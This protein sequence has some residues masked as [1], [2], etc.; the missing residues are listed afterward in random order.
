MITELKLT[1]VNEQWHLLRE[2]LH[3]KTSIGQIHAVSRPYARDAAQKMGCHP[4]DDLF[5]TVPKGFLTDLASI[6]K[7]LQKALPPDGEYAPA[8]VVHDYLYQLLVGN[9][10]TLSGRFQQALGRFGADRVFLLA[11]RECGCSESLSTMFFSSVQ[12][13]GGQYYQKPTDA[14]VLN[15]GN[16]FKVPYDYVGIRKSL[17]PSIPEHHYTAPATGDKTSLKYTNCLRPFYLSEV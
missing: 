3:F 5:I 6:P 4:D 13:A 7:M 9:S 2:D 8:A 1:S 15:E 12:A 10:D 16:V 14:P 17:A 11:M